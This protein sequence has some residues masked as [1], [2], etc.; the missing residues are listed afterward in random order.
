ME[1]IHWHRLGKEPRWRSAC[2]CWI[3]YSLSDNS[4]GPQTIVN[5]FKLASTA[6]LRRSL[7]TASRSRAL[8]STA[9]AFVQ[10]GDSIPSINL[11]ENSPGNQVNLAEQIKGKALI[12]GVPG[13]FSMCYGGDFVFRR[14][15]DQYPGPACSESHVPGYIN[16]KNIKDAGDVYV[17]AVNDAFV[18]VSSK[19]VI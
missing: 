1:W 2:N 6:M 10:V 4:P 11:V 17:V 16:H 15:A 19:V 9:R 14:V 3:T 8:H 5:H 12:I 18:W 13:A 7:L